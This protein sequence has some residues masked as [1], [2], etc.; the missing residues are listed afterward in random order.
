MRQ[1]T[2]DLDLETPF[3]VSHFGQALRQ[4]KVSFVDLTHVDVYVLG[5]DDGPG[6]FI[7]SWQQLRDSWTRYFKGAGT[8]LKTYSVLRETPRL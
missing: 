1:S 6:D 4:G 5:A 7:S 2:S 8:N 3:G